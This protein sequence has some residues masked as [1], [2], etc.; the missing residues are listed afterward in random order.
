MKKKKNIVNFFL[1]K[2]KYW[3]NSNKDSKKK[4]LIFPNL[5][6]NKTALSINDDKRIQSFNFQKFLT[7]VISKEIIDK[8]K[9]INKRIIMETCK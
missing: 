7:Y 3:E 2:A 4:E 6:V 1:V 8:N 9:K 5:E